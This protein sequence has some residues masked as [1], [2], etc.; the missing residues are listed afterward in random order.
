MTAS[1][2]RRAS[3]A[4]IASRWPGRRASKP[5]VSRATR[6]MRSPGITAIA[7]GIPAAKAEKTRSA[8]QAF[9]DPAELVLGQVEGRV[10]P[11]HAHNRLVEGDA[12]GLAVAER[13][14]HDGAAGGAAG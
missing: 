13:V 8:D 9:D 4:S 14:E 7:A 10:R 2:S 3:T 1:A 6:S 11:R 12:P 5:N